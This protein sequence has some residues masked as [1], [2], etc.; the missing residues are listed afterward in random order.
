MQ[1]NQSEIAEIFN[2]LIPTYSEQMDLYL[3]PVIPYKGDV[4]RRKTKPWWNQELTRLWK[5]ARKAEKE[6]HKAKRHGENNSMIM[7]LKN[8]FKSHRAMFDKTFLLE[9]TLIFTHARYLHRPPHASGTYLP[10]VSEAVSHGPS[11]NTDLTLVYPVCYLIL[12][13][14]P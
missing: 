1:I 2:K 14:K 7:D 8:N 4:K 10:G 12:G 3:E 11:S 9:R 5:T 6:L 13:L